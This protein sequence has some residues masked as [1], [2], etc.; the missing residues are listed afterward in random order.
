VPSWTGP[1]R[2]SAGAAVSSSA[3]SVARR[4]LTP[5]R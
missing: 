2:A 3:A 4:T 5:P 1:L